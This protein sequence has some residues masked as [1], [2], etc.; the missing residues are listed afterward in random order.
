MPFWARMKLQKFGKRSCSGRIP[1]SS[2]PRWFFKSLAKDK[3]RDQVVPFA[4]HLGLRF[5]LSTVD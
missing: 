3:D 1:G 4:L 2:L 5:V